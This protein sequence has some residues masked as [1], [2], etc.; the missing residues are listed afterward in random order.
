MQAFDRIATPSV[1][2]TPVSDAI[3]AFKAARDC[4]AAA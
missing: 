2:G 4:R 1:F 3:R